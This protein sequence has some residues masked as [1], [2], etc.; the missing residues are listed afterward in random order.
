[1]A[2]SAILGTGP[3]RENGSLIRS[4]Q[5]KADRVVVLI[6]GAPGLSAGQAYRL[7]GP[8]EPIAVWEQW[9]AGYKNYAIV[10]TVEAEETRSIQLSTRDRQHTFD[11]SVKLRGRVVDAVRHLKDIGA[12]SNTSRF[13]GIFSAVENALKENAKSLDRKSVV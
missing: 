1:M 9:T 6:R 12:D 13:G 11:V 8:N 5:A 4:E 3:T 2:N 10:S 7:C